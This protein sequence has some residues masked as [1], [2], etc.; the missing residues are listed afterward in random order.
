MIRHLDALFDWSIVS[1]G[2]LLQTDSEAIVGLLSSAFGA[3]QSTFIHN[4]ISVLYIILA[5]SRIVRSIQNMPATHIV[6]RIIDW[7]KAMI[8][9]S[10]PPYEA[11]FQRR[12]ER[13]QFDRAIKKESNVRP[14]YKDSEKHPQNNR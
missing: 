4:V 11:Y 2:Y 12:R 7:F 6:F 10:R 8:D 1:L 14:L 5:I 13:R 3:T 9:K